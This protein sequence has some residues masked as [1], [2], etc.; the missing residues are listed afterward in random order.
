VTLHRLA[1]LG[2][3][4]LAALP[5]SLAAQTFQGKIR[6]RT[7]QIAVGED[8][9]RPESLFDVAVGAL[10]QREGAEV[11]E[12]TLLINRAGR[13]QEAGDARAT[14]TTRAR[15]QRNAHRSERAADA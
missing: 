10:M 4:L 3:A 9:A 8:D 6:F 12:A 1:P 5:I 14:L 11:S 15:L 2:T 13:L 7:V